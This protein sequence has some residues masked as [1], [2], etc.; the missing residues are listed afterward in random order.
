MNSSLLV[1]IS[2][3]PAQTADCYMKEKP[4]LMAMNRWQFCWCGSGGCAMRI[5]ERIEWDPTPK[6]RCIQLPFSGS[7]AKLISR[8]LMSYSLYPSCILSGVCGKIHS[9][10]FIVSPTMVAL[11][12]SDRSVRRDISWQLP[13]SGDTIKGTLYQ[14]LSG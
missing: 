12:H 3:G 1:F 13:C 6:R 9:V 2:Y 11:S 14:V 4:I 7:W 10:H 5:R 8:V